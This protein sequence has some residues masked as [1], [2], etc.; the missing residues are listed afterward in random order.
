MDVV[1]KIILYK[2]GVA[3]TASCNT[4]NSNGNWKNMVTFIADDEDFN[5]HL[6]AET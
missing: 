1:N 6:D 2:S 3:P 4:I 5:L